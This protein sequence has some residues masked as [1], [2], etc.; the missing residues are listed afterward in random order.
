[1]DLLLWFYAR[2]SGRSTL[3]A[4]T[5]FEPVVR[6]LQP[7]ALPL[8]YGARDRPPHG[9][10]GTTPVGVPASGLSVDGMDRVLRAR[11]REVAR[12][13]RSP[14]DL[15]GPRSYG[16]YGRIS[17]PACRVEGFWRR[18]TFRRLRVRSSPWR[19]FGCAA[20][21]RHDGLSERSA[22]GL[23]GCRGIEPR[24]PG[25]ESSLIPRSQPMPDSR[26]ACSHSSSPSR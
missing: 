22:Y 24:W 16:K 10:P 1:M 2:S 25:L 9:G 4:P 20:V 12:V 26:R 5:G 8:G 23:A 19:L 3:E 17:Q 13:A 18:R 11:G 21:L 7:R 6:G 14:W 15:D